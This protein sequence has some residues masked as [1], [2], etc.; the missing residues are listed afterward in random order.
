MWADISIYNG[1]QKVKVH[2]TFRAQLTFPTW[3]SSFTPAR[4]LKSTLFESTY[5][6]DFLLQKVY[7]Q[8]PW[9]DY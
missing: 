3:L 4:V 5:S 6:E 1:G 7:F 9:K 2:L 8:L